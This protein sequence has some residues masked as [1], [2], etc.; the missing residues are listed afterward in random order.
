M[1][2]WDKSGTGQSMD[3]SGTGGG[4]GRGAGSEQERT[5]ASSM[6]TGLEVDRAPR[7]WKVPFSVT[8]ET[9]SPV[10]NCT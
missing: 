7:D 4:G 9:R 1:K 10:L 2:A 3:F 6:S 5:E 8:G